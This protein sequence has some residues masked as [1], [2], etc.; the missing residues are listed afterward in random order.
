MSKIQQVLKTVRAKHILFLVGIYLVSAGISWA[1]FSYI[2]RGEGGKIISPAGI[3]GKRAR[4]NTN[5]PKTEACPLNGLKYTKAEKEIWET[6]RPLAVMIENHE[7]A[8]PQSGL[9]KADIVYEAVAEGGITRFLAV[10]YCGVSAE[11]LKV[12]PVRSARVYFMDWASEYG[13]YP[14]YAHVGGA[15]RPG[16]ADALGLISNYKWSLY[17]DLNQFSIPFPTFEKDI[18]RLKRSDGSQIATEHTMYAYTDKLWEYAREERELTNVDKK[19]N[20][21]DKN[22]VPWKFKEDVTGGNIASVSFPFW[23]GQQNYAV[24]WNFDSVSGLWK[25]ENGGQS[26]LDFNTKE[27]IGAANLVLQFTTEKALKDPEKHM[28]YTTI[29]SGK[30]L[31]FHKGNV[32][33]GTWKKQ[34]RTGRT[35]FFDQSGREITFVPGQIWIEILANGTEVEY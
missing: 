10:F 8:R 2:S 5:V 19:G 22:F 31:I 11:E 32:V 14:L 13:D 35:I 33:T 9:S 1:V 21:W 28:L 34:D 20:S 15:N 29:G 25:R 12:G 24:K 6:R 3:G 18:E 23:S 7:E 4:I 26:H 17:N 27:Q 16:P 30:A